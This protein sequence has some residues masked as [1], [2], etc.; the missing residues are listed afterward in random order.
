MSHFELD[1]SLYVIPS[2][3]GAYFSAAS[4]EQSK[5]KNLIIHLMRGR[6]SVRLDS[7]K[8]KK[9]TSS[10]SD[11]NAFKILYQAQ[12]EQWIQGVEDMINLPDQSLENTLPNLLSTLTT[13]G[14]VLLADNEGLSVHAVGFSANA[15]EELAALSADIGLLHER[16]HSV[17]QSHLDLSTSAWGVIDAAGNTH[18]GFWPLYI[19]QQRFVLCI[20]G[21]P[22]LNSPN[23]VTLIWL[24]NNRYQVF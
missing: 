14:N 21:I 15:A 19:G 1:T 2:P 13:T 20:E 24:L 10:N 9:W 8:L 4:P 18:L 12:K 16:H 7:E 3:A 17:W 11:D 6:K 23:L 5:I 22:R